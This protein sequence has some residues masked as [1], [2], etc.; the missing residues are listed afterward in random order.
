MKR[1]FLRLSDTLPERFLERLAEGSQPFRAVCGALSSSEVKCSQHS[2]LQCVPG[3]GMCFP[4]STPVFSLPGFFSP[5]KTPKPVSWNPYTSFFIS[6]YYLCR[7]NKTGNWVTLRALLSLRL[8]PGYQS[9]RPCVPFCPFLSS[10]TG[11]RDLMF[12]N[13]AHF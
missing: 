3:S 12:H 8:F 5:W 13:Y 2:T 10:N 6:V 7:L 1:I 9:N 11:I 4:S